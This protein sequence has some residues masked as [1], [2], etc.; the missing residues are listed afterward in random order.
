MA[1]VAVG[2]FS[3]AAGNRR[4]SGIEGAEDEEKACC[5]NRLI[6]GLNRVVLARVL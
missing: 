6:D 1:F 5:D 2:F 4:A 3:S